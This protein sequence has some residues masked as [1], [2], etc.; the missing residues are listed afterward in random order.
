MKRRSLDGKA[1]AL[2]FYEYNM[3]Y[4][5]IIVNIYIYIY[6]YIYMW[7]YIFAR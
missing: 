3:T 4:Y 7:I 2:G 1:W 5:D 6:K